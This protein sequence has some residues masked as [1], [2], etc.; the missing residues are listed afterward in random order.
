MVMEDLVGENKIKEEQDDLDEETLRP[1]QL[2]N[3][4]ECKK[5][6]DEHARD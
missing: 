1:S 2:Q 3:F 4:L 5:A 6:K